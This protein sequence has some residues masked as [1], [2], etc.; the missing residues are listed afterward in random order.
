M[1]PVIGLTTQP[2][3]IASAAGELDSHVLGHTYTDSVLRAGG[4]TILLTPVPDTEI[5]AILDRIDGLVLTGGGDI[6]P[7]RY[8]EEPHETVQTVDFDRDEFEFRLIRGARDR[9][10]PVLAIC[11]GIQV[12][13][14]AF[15]GSLIQDIAS[16]IGSMD[17]DQF[18]HLVWDGH[19]PIKIEPGCLIGE[20]IG[21]TELMVN[22]IHHQAIRDLAPGLSAVAWAG[23]GIVE[24]VQHED[25]QWPLLAVQWHPEFLGDRDDAASF[26]LFSSLVDAARRHSTFV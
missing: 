17:H 2:K 4:L 11:R 9:R 3:P 6:D 23:D 15:G 16:E 18:G 7:R 14:V 26:A 1:H 19:Q 8:G 12:L 22:S 5:D 25:E 10:M 13:N 21:D 20:V 24:A